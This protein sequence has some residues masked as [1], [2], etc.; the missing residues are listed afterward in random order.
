MATASHGLTL[1]LLHYNTILYPQWQEGGAK[2]IKQTPNML[3]ENHKTKWLQATSQYP[4]QV[5]LCL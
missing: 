4:L 3:I 5:I 2:A 1:A